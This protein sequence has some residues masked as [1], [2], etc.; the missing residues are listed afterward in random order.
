MT[1]QRPSTGGGGGAPTNAEYVV[2]STNGTLSNERV[3]TAGSGITL[4]DAGAGSTIT[5][6]ATGGSGAPTGASYVTLGTDGTLTA[7]RVL[8]AG[9]GISLTDAG[10]GSTLTVAT[11]IA[12]TIAYKSSDQT[13][14]GT[15][16]ADVT[17]TGLSVAANTAYWFEFYILIDADAV[18]TGIDVAVNGP[19]SPTALSYQQLYWTS[20]TATAIRGANAYDNNP[21]ST[22]SNGTAARVFEVRGIIVNGA[23]AGTLIARAKREAVGTGPN[24]R[25]GSFG[26]LTKL[27]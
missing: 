2:L 25:K 10:A 14:I 15:A 1:Y 8:T 4:T 7:E 16:Y 23:N 17:G 13:L 20:A 27:S 21:A 5:I 18:T 6:A 3:L 26:R 12:T 11:S 22:A 19:A 9:T 24:V